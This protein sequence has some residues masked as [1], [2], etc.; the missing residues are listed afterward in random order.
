MYKR[1]TL[2]FLLLL[3]LSSC[4]NKY[5]KNTLSY[6]TNMLLDKNV[7]VISVYSSSAMDSSPWKSPFSVKEFVSRLFYQV[8]QNKITLYNPIFDDTIFH[9]LDKE[10]WLSLLK[11]N[12]QQTFD[13]TEFSDFYFYE[14]WT[15]DTTESFLFNKEVVFWSPIKYNKEE[16]SKIL[17]GKVSCSDTSNLQLLAKHVI[18]EF[19]LDDTLNVNRS[20]NKNL[21]VKLIIDKALNGQI[22]V[23]HPN[24]GKKLSKNELNERLD[25]TDSSLY[26][27]YYNIYSLVFIEN[28][29][30]NPNT[31]AIKKEIVGIAPVKQIYLD[32]EVT[33]SIIFVL[34]LKEKP[35]TLL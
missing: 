27:P 22:P 35:F 6:Q 17:T 15:L 8:L 16:K 32:D 7:S 11:N 24:N 13:T 1:V 33:K 3:I 29:Y 14:H 25:I 30:Y 20:L 9:P 4:Q 23:Y 2:L 31:F 19:L 34:F 5:E 18:Y 26:M 28:W 10:A 12:K 21:L